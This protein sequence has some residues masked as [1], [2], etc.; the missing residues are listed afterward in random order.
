MIVLAS[1]IHS[2]PGVLNPSLRPN[3]SLQC[4]GGQAGPCCPQPRSELG[5]WIVHAHWIVHVQFRPDQPKVHMRSPAGLWELRTS[6]LIHSHM[7][8]QCDAPME[9]PTL[10]ASL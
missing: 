5:M 9:L 6:A 1:C 4:V 8:K 7:H 10:T 2:N 3:A